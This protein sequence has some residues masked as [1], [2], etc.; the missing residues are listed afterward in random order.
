MASA[1]VVKPTRDGRRLWHPTLGAWVTGGG[2]RFRVWAPEIERVELVLE[3]HPSGLEDARSVILTRQP[4]GT[5]ATR[6]DDVGPGARYRYRLDGRGPFPDPVSRAQ[7]D[8]VHGASEVVDPTFS[9]TDQGWSGL[10]LRDAVVYELHVGTFTPAGTFA[11]VT[12]RLP[13]L[14]QLGVSAVELM[15]VAESA[16]M[17]NWGYDG[18][19]LFAPSHVYGSPDDLRRLVNRAHELSLAVV[20][21]VVYNHLGPD[22]AYHAEFSPYYFSPDRQSPW[23]PAIN[24]DGTRSDQTRAFFVEN[25]LYWLHEYH[26]DGLRLDAT[27]A[28][29]DDSPTHIIAELASRVRASERGD[30]LLIAED[31]RNATVVVTPLEE[32]GWGL[33]GVWADDLH[34]Q[35]R[36]ATAGDSDGYFHDYSGSMEDLVQTICQGWFYRGER[37]RYLEAQQG[38]DPAGLPFKRFV[39]C[40]QN[41]DQVGNRALGDRLHHAVDPAVYRA[42]VTLVCCLPETPLLFMGQE[43]AASAP[44]QY[45]TDHH[46]ALG[47][48][49]TEGRRQALSRF[50]L[51][52]DPAARERI[53]DP[54]APSTFET[55]RLDWSEREQAG[56]VHVYRLHAAVLALRG[57]TAAFRGPSVSGDP[58]A[59]AIGA[60]TV[61]VTRT[62]LEG[63]AGVVVVCHI[64]GPDTV[65]LDD[66]P[67]TRTGWDVH[68]STEDTEFVEQSIPITVST[69][70]SPSIRF[71]RPGAV[72]LRARTTR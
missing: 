37:S 29:A 52:S 18:V 25:A 39:V 50:R 45:F 55:S 10:A 26:L 32:G 53:P 36:R 63:D 47:R 2:T 43:W 33:D 56:H 48:M 31:G 64:G 19:A 21:D 24:Y 61:A 7:P 60:R 67:D 62:G 27:H 66:G 8:G 51:F 57:T 17:R 20:L 71:G 30:S 42:L 23:G 15:P 59:V 54:Q 38:T 34:H 69:G 68:L 72:V 44:F 28:I 11:G 46:E 58:V 22:G 49:V 6:C 41:H 70:S 14:A 35:I 13:Y 65:R 4:D 40:L 1:R 5:H 16:G 12:E 9:W 3:G